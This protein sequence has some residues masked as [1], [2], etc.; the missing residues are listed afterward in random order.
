MA[1]SID[2]KKAPAKSG[3]FREPCQWTTY[4]ILRFERNHRIRAGEAAEPCRAQPSGLLSRPDAAERVRAGKSASGGVAAQGDIDRLTS[5]HA[6]FARDHLRISAHPGDET[7]LQ[8]REL[9]LR[10]CATR[11]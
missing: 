8:S 2:P 7:T 1:I 6:E 9:D 4:K 3:P 11:G 5:A 10:C